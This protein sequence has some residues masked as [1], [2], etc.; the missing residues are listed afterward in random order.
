MTPKSLLRNDLASSPLNSVSEEELKL[1]IPEIDD[2]RKED[3]SRVILCSGKV[4][5]DLLLARR[6][7]NMNNV[8]IVRVERL[9]PF[10]EKEIKDLL[11]S[12]DK[13]KDLVWCQ[14]EPKNQG[15]WSYIYPRIKGLLQEN[16]H[17][18]YVG[19]EEMAATA[20]GYKRLFKKQQDNLIKQALNVE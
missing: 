12:Y 8:A 3:V 17:I 13:M 1:I 11:Q 9:Y 15:A 14:E 10:P 5:Y 6:A 20:D 7:K 19:R 4:Y 2:I 16:A 18:I